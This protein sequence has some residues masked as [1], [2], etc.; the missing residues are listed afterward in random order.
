MKILKG[1]LYVL[2]ALIAVLA[3]AVGTL[4]F[5]PQVFLNTGAL[6][7]AISKQSFVRLEPAVPEGLFFQVKSRSFAVKSI[8]LKS[9]AFCVNAPEKSQPPGSLKW[10][11]CM[12]AMDVNLRFSL[13]SGFRPVLRRIGPIALKLKEG[14]VEAASGATEAP[15]PPE[16]SAR[17][18]PAW[19]PK[20]AKDLHVDPLAIEIERLEFRDG[21][22]RQALRAKVKGAELPEGGKGFREMG[23]EAIAELDSNRD[24]RKVSVESKFVLNR[25]LVAKGDLDAKILTRGKRP[26]IRAQAAFD[27]DLR[28]ESILLEGKGTLTEIVPYVPWVSLDRFRIEKGEKIKAS[29]D[30][31]LELG[32]GQPSAV[33]R[34]SLP[35]PRIQ[36]RFRAK[37]EATSSD[38]ESFDAQLSLDRSK[39]SGVEIEVGAKAGFDA[40]KSALQLHQAWI[41]FSV[42]DFRQVVRSLERTQLAIPAPFNELKGSFAVRAGERS[43]AL[44]VDRDRTVVPLE[45]VSDLKSPT[46][47]FVTE[48]RGKLLL[49]SSPFKADLSFDDVLK[50]VRLQAPDLNPVLPI[51]MP[52]KDSR[53]VGRVS[54]GADDP[55]KEEWS[56]PEAER[57]K[58]KEPPSFSYDIRVRTEQR[59]VEVLYRLF[60]PYAAFTADF[61]LRSKPKGSGFPSLS[62][63]F[64]RMD[65]EFMARKARLEKFTVRKNPTDEPIALNARLGM[66]KAGYRITAEFEQLGGRAMIDLKSDPPLSNDDIVSL[67]LF[68]QLSSDLD[69]ESSDSVQDTQVAISKRAL[70]FF[71]FWALSSTP[72][73]A[74]SYDPATQ[75]YSARVSLPGQLSATVGSDWEESQIVGL[76]KRLS[77]KWSVSTEYR[78][79]SDGRSRQE[80][81]VEWFTRY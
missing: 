4:W 81:M 6:E 12:D 19:F 18:W 29:A 31:R 20:P 43:G 28:K 25:D 58:S 65:V 21:K 68:N 60:S 11:F 30:V 46:Q 51:P 10:R 2:G 14:W 27:V 78:T 73:E 74:V 56:D 57:K 23:F 17:F 54:R 22:K 50:K 41:E 42:P 36:K 38:G 26:S 32:I 75:I 39:Q 52:M 66:D 44:K 62:L 34:S 71:S 47:S 5:F 76:R 35:P 8:E 16:P 48:G 37:L 49:K 67:L 55:K 59:P 69:S 70:G 53:I 15:K 7:W 64:S 72:I 9:A 80:T 79:F 40:K 13:T 3:L 24:P 61:R 45:I 77:G 63:D 1:F 33:R